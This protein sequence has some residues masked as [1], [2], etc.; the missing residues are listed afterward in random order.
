MLDREV[1]KVRKENDSRGVRDT[2]QK[3]KD[4]ELEERKKEEEMRNDEEENNNKNAVVLQE[5]E[6]E[7]SF[8]APTKN[9]WRNMM[10]LTGTAQTS[11]RYELSVRSTAA[12]TSAYLGDLI[13][14]GMGRYPPVSPSQLW[15]QGSCRELE[16]KRWR[17]QL[18][19]VRH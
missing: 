11:M 18:S 14:S 19:L 6:E 16:T 8:T 3:L 2:N 9:K 15:T 1:L 10:D 7:E 4:L 12:V 5:E 17:K 13:T